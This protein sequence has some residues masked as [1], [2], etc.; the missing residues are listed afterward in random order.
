MTLKCLEI[1]AG[2]ATMLAPVLREQKLGQVT[3]AAAGEQGGGK[4]KGGQ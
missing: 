1:E 4:W 3:Q 2:E